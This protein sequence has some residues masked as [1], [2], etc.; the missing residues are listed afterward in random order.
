MKTF[1]K[2]LALG[3]AI[4]AAAILAPAAFAQGDRKSVV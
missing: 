3:A 4:T 1:N 2:T